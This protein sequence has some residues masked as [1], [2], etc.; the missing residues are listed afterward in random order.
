MPT[1]V[2][3]HHEHKPD[4]NR[5]A[6]WLYEN[7]LELARANMETRPDPT[8]KTT[9]LAET[10]TDPDRQQNEELKPGPTR[11]GKDSKPDVGSGQLSFKP[12]TRIDPNRPGPFMWFG[13]PTCLHGCS[14][15]RDV[16]YAR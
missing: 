11:P 15:R 7:R 14:R 9:R 4:P 10:R 16:V 1:R 8:H 3:T 6:M 5:P 13:D 2:S 12:L